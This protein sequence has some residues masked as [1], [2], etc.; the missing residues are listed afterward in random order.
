[1]KVDGSMKSLLQGVSQQPPRDR[2]PG[3]ATL[4][5]NMTSD[6]VSGLTRRPPTDLVGFLGT[7]STVRGFH[8]FNTRDGN[9]FL[10]WFHND[11]LKVFDLNGEEYTVTVDTGAETYLA[12]TGV[13]RA[14]TDEE[15][16][17]VV[18]SQDV[19][20]LMAADT[21][22][23]WNHDGRSAAIVQILGGLY[24][25]SYKISIDG[26]TKGTFTTPDGSVATH[27]DKIDTVHIATQL[28]NDL[29]TNLGA[30]YTITRREDIILVYSDTVEFNATAS[31]GAGNINIKC[32]NKTVSDVADLPRM[33]PHRYVVRVAE[34][35]DPEK[36]LWLKFV[37]D[38]LEDDPTSTL[39]AF[40]KSG[41][42][43]E[44]VAPD[45][46]Y[47]F[48][49]ST[50]PHH[51]T[52]SGG[53]FTFSQGPWEDREVGTL[54][55]NPEPS[56]IGNEIKDVTNF[57][58]RLVFVAGSNVVTSR[59][60]RPYNFW[61]GS[62]SALADTD[63]LDVNSTVE[64]SNMVHAIQHNRDLVIFSKE[65][66]FVMF[67]RTKA[68]PENVALVMSTKFEASEEAH[69]VG[70]G[71]NVFFATKYGLYTGIREFFAEGAT[72]I[73]DSRP[74]T[75]HVKKFIEGDA[76]HLSCSANYDTLLVHT[77]TQQNLV[78]V[79]QYIW[80]DVDKVQSAWH[81]WRFAE[82]IIFSFF[83]EDRVYYI[84]KVGNEY[85]LLRMPIDVQD[86]E[87]V[88]YPVYLDQRF[89]VP[90]ME[91]QFL[92]PYDYLH[93]KELVCVQGAGCP[94]P[95]MA[96]PVQ[97]I[98]YDAG[99]V[100]YVLTTKRS[101][102]GGN[103]IVGVRYTSRYRPTMPFI[104][105]A[106]GIVV[107]TGNMRI[108]NFLVS[109]HQTGELVGYTTSKYGNGEEVRYNGRVV[110][111]VDNVVGETTLG[112]GQFVMPFRQNSDQAEVEFYT[113]S[114]MPATLLDIEWQGQYNKRGRRI[115]GGA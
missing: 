15:D 86:S 106:D 48:N 26:E 33:A 98:E 102:N 63:P 54:V 64:A 31:D 95:G 108:R 72:E 11:T 45:V 28:A 20:A 109:V 87:G 16:A 110:G 44:C 81:N 13:V 71:K 115:A 105:D 112:T 107:G 24:G 84:Q 23:Y 53:E 101:M 38:A 96:A 57:Q 2:L 76:K 88:G 91:T 41:Y 6:P 99:L 4:Q 21:P 42:W 79:Y 39:T 7:A 40:G 111:D 97:S 103:L 18:V 59:T 73:N 83:E 82:D 9:K 10:A 62:A 65:A 22:N 77:G 25:K 3:Q 92:L 94:N 69:P 60:N 19:T 51:L 43:Q 85:Y 75:Q 89:D 93:D 114:Y 50:M 35:T 30:N 113:D 14:S 8:T 46:P 55:S 78:S 47:K 74:I 32:M 52:Y 49:L 12:A 37:A 70:A 61:F 67:G 27:S 1:M 56:F 34:K 17:T 29:D 68:T 58:G 5:E 100:G 104:K 36:D 66:Q 80:A 90:G